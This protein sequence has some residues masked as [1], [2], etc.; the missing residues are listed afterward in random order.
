MP[1]PPAKPLGYVFGYA[2]LVAD[3]RSLSVAGEAVAP[4][5]GR[6]YG[7]RRLWGAAMNNWEK[8]EGEK[9][10]VEPGSGAKPRVRVAYL[11]IEPAAGETVNGLAIPVD[12]PLLAALDAREVNYE[13]LDVS[14]AFRPALDA[15]VLAYR[16]TAAARARCRPRPG[17]AVAVSREYVRRVRAGFAALGHEQLAEYERTTL[18]LPFA[19]RDLEPRGPGSA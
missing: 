2:S 6:L 8:G 14:A 16:G 12:A 13:R 11:D 5:A 17:V 4:V 19:E 15:P 3:A 1:A 9:H 7:F 18:P 10:F